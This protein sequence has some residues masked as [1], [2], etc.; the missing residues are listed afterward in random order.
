MRRSALGVIAVAGLF[1]ATAHAQIS[2]SSAVD[3]AFRSDPKV[4]AAK[5]DV[6]RSR[7][8][9]SESKDAF[10]P[11][12]N[13]DG[14]VGRS[15]GVP[16]GLPT[17]FTLTAQSLAFNWSQ[18]DYVRAAHIG[19]DSSRYALQQAEDDAAE[20]VANTYIALDNEQQRRATAQDA[21]DH[22]QRLLTIVKDR[23]AAGA[24]PH[25]EIPRT[26]LTVIEIEQQLSVVNHDIATLSD[27]LARLT[28]L[29]GGSL[30]AMHNT[31]PPLP[32][33]AALAQ[34]AAPSPLS[35][36]GLQAA[37]ANASSKAEIALGDKR[38]LYRPQL[39]FEAAYSRV[40]TDFSNYD[41]YYPA[42]NPDN[43]GHAPLSL[44]A[45]SVGVSIRLPLLDQAH[46]AKARESAADAER[47]KDDAL[48][49][50]NQFLEGHLK[51][52]LSASDLDF[53]A[54][55]A[56]D[57]E[58]IAQD[59]L[60]AVLVQLQPNAATPN[61]QPLTPK[62]EEN[63]RL[64]LDQRRLELLRA[65]LDLTQA[66]IS[67]MRQNGQLSSWLHA[68]FGIALAPASHP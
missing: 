60:N 12:V 26:D 25:V 20:D 4:L 22:A 64:A 35:N 33:T 14:G 45:L 19:W 13:A 36:P 27:H 41:I 18:R 34:A 6:D 16:L 67:L 46:R 38:Y 68:A 21:L 43:P 23:V 28:G 2:L 57:N 29:T 15:A 62:D 65:Q 52:Q 32:D 44:N 10:V 1:C 3:L 56:E 47:A 53:A 58:E 24:D 39:A 66:K 17:S 8:A 9:L 42:F 11:V 7:A 51:L 61:S 50:Q 49:Q 31:I 54:R 63:A 5:A 40:T 48:V 55:K 30:S 59:D 37:F